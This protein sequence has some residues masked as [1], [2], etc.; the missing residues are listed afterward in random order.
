MQ[1]QTE[2]PP[3]VES[4]DSFFIQSIVARARATT[5]DI[6]SEMF[7]EKSGYEVKKYKLRVL[8]VPPEPAIASPDEGRI[9]GVARV[10]S[11]PSLH[12]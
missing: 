11:G 7:E 2:A 4:K 6:T 12:P 3:D 8:Y 10:G 1:A 9:Q 5:K